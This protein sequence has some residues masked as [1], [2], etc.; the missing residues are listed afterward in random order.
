MMLFLIDGLDGR[1][2]FVGMVPPC[3]ASATRRR[4]A[5]I[6]ARR[7]VVAGAAAT[8]RRRARRQRV[9]M[10]SQLAVV[11]GVSA[12]HLVPQLCA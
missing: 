4:P 10:R 2:I 9:K 11:L 12:L 5:V 8:E 1:Y 7:H 6:R 3:C